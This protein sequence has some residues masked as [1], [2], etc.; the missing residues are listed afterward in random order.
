MQFPLSAGVGCQDLLWLSPAEPTQGLWYWS[1]YWCNAVVSAVPHISTSISRFSSDLTE[2]PSLLRERK[3]VFIPVLKFLSQ[4]FEPCW[5]SRHH[6]DGL[7]PKPHHPN[8]VCLVSN[9][10][11]AMGTWCCSG[12]WTRCTSYLS[13]GWLCKLIALKLNIL[14]YFLLI[15]LNV[16]LGVCSFPLPAH[17][18]PLINCSR[19]CSPSPISVGLP[20]LSAVTT[21]SACMGS[22]QCPK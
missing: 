16:K 20:Q 13:L 9:K 1:Q 10:Y 22:N 12:C 7:K 21:L 3:R 11:V 8:Y 5:C 18:P 4:Y 14:S 17:P 6:S 15:N 19:P 2:M